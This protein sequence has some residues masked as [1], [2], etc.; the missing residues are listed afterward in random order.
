MSERKVEKKETQANNITNSTQTQNN[1]NLSSNSTPAY[2]SLHLK[3]RP[4]RRAKPS[5]SSIIKIILEFSF[6]LLTFFLTLKKAINVVMR[7]KHPVKE[8]ISINKVV[9]HNK[10]NISPIK[11]IKKE[12]KV[13]LCTIG[14]LENRYIKEFI[15]FYQNFGVDK[16]FLYDNN[17]K[18]GEKFDEIIKD[19]INKGYVEISNWRGK[20]NE[21][22]NMMNDCYRKNNQL[23]DWLIFYDI[24]EYIHLNNYTNIKTFLNE[25]KFDN[26]KKI[27]LN[28]VFHT[29]NSLF[30]YDNR[31]LKERFPEK[32]TK[33]EKLEKNNFNYIK[34]II[35]GNLPNIKIDCKYTLSKEIQGCNAFG[36]ISNLNGLNMEELDFDNYYIDHYFYKTLDEFIEKLTSKDYD[37]K[38][39]N[40]TI[41]KYFEIN[42]LAYEKIAYLENRTGINLSE[43]H[44]KLK[45][46]QNR[47]KKI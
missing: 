31:T 21:T 22:L 27:Y 41:K 28:W 2:H 34:S 10:T 13:G 11:K 1:N 40:E 44:K 37:I 23:Y 12:I 8:E 24:D 36:K 38:F 25:Y 9:F 42:E 6:L 33:P 47:N 45:N 46:K 4:L 14:K 3:K 43:Y 7:N 18:K 16:I 32:E 5:L 17:K 35:R 39:K 29:D 15:E 19:Y 30:H 26:C 20:K